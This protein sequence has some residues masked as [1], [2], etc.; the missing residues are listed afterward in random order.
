MQEM[1]DGAWENCGRVVQVGERR[2][3]VGCGAVEG[4][5]LDEADAGQVF[6]IVGAGAEE[7]ERLGERERAGNGAGVGGGGGSRRGGGGERDDE[8]A[9]GV[10]PNLWGGRSVRR[11][12][13]SRRVR[14]Y[15][16]VR[17]LGVQPFRER[18]GR[19]DEQKLAVRVVDTAVISEM[20]S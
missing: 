8:E 7:R 13:K 11:S 16:V 5:F 17:N 10:K 20:N 4:L 3:G 19:L 9:A 18:V 12:K 15:P 14:A 2:G 1:S 6:G